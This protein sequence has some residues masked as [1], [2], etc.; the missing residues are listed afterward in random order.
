MCLCL[1]LIFDPRCTSPYAMTFPLAE[2]FC[3]FDTGKGS[4]KDI[5]FGAGVD[6][7]FSR[8]LG[9]ARSGN[10]TSYKMEL[11]GEWPGDRVPRPRQ[12]G[13][14]NHYFA[15]VRHYQH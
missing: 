15:N 8:D 1:Y 2:A 7:I 3:K 12:G 4:Q 11:R 14:H 13:R 6:G 5:A 10:D 9:S